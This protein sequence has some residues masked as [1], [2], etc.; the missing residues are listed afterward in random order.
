MSSILSLNPVT[1]DPT[2]TLRSLVRSLIENDIHRVWIVEGPGSKR[3][4]D[5][6]TH[7][8]VIKVV[9]DSA[10]SLRQQGA[11]GLVL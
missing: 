4:V 7:S 6:V 5:V 2:T 9:V 10:K 11:V 3:P 8:D 1:A